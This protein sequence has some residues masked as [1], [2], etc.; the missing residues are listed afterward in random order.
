[1][2]FNTGTNRALG[3]YEDFLTVCVW[4]SPSSVRV[5]HA[6]VRVGSVGDERA[7]CEFAMS[8]FVS[9]LL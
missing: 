4:V 2:P 3:T 7:G 1:M 6:F 9:I 5:L 8:C